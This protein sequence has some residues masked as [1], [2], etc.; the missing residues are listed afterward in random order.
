MAVEGGYAY[1]ADRRSGLHILDVSQP[2][3]P[4][5]I[6]TVNTPGNALDVEVAGSYAYVA[7]YNRGLRIIDISDP[8]RP[9]EVGAYGLD[10][11]W[12]V[13][14]AGDYA[15]VADGRYGLRVVDISV[16]SNAYEVSYFDEVE[17]AY[18]VAVAGDYAYLADDDGGVR[19]VDVS[20]PERPGE[21]GYYRTPDRTYG[22]AASD[23]L[24]YAASKTGGLHIIRNLSDSDE[25]ITDSSDECDWPEGGVVKLKVVAPT[26][27]NLSRVEAAKSVSFIPL[28]NEQCFY[29]DRALVAS[30]GEVEEIRLIDERENLLGHMPFN[31]KK[32]DGLIEAVLFLHADVPT[33]RGAYPGWGYYETDREHPV[34]MLIPPDGRFDAIGVT[35]EEPLLLVHGVGGVYPYWDENLIVALN[36]KYDVWQLYYPYDQQ[37]QKSGLLLGRALSQLTT[38]EG[39]AEY[40]KLGGKVNIVAHSMGGLVARSYMQGQSARI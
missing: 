32:E 16:P 38:A 21:I 29:L 13:A 26:T 11:V 6:A 34:S 24:V 3:E 2:T 20:D 7:D 23:G 1:V 35:D 27:S 28:S 30:V 5:R 4:T 19:I 36:Q 31:Y 12:D 9:Q 37:I 8:S 39:L 15:Y 25:G 40:G 18:D 10:Y 17:D 22:I 33:N 14:V